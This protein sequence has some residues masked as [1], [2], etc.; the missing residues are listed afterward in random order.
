MEVLIQNINKIHTTEL[1]KKRIASNISIPEDTVVLWCQDMIQS[2]EATITRAG[3]NWYVRNKG[4]VITINATSYTII[5]AHKNKRKVEYGKAPD[6]DEWMR[7]VADLRYNFPGLETDEGIMEHR[8]TVL[9]FMKEQRA[10]CVKENDRIIGVLLFSRK[11]N[12]ICCLGVD[13]HY[14]KQGIAD[15]LMQSALT[16]LD[17]SKDISVSTF[18][19]E[20]EL[21]KAP[22]ALYKKYGFTEGDLIMEFNYP[23][24][25]FIKHPLF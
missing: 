12:M 23:S 15:L 18:R 20:D 2:K 24:Q 8:Q 19:E 6:I 10:L 16:Q 17:N 22:R 7:L 9:R 3:K 1:G 13:I 25:L 14:R 4:I 11:H 5:T 21:G